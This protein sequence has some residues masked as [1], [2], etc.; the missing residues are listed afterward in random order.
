MS[1]SSARSANTGMSVFSL[2]G[3]TSAGENNADVAALLAAMSPDDALNVILQQQLPSRGNVGVPTQGGELTAGN[4][5]PA[6]NNTPSL[7][8]GQQGGELTATMEP[9]VVMDISTPPGLPQ[10]PDMPDSNM[11]AGPA[12][13][14]RA[15]TSFKMAAASPPRGR[16]PTSNVSSRGNSK[17]PPTPLLENRLKAAQ[18]ANDRLEKEKLELERR[19]ARVS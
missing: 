13:V 9:P 5:L 17:P 12:T 16:R 7:T 14:V 1:D 18:Q 19:L 4:A 8:N 6:A 3:T 15:P 10:I 2:S 11:R